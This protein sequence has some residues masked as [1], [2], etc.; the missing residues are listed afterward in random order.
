LQDVLVGK[1]LVV[2]TITAAQDGF[3]VAVDI[4]RKAN[5]SAKVIVVATSLERTIAP[6]REFP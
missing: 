2:N 4:P 5:P 3:L 1:A 6:R